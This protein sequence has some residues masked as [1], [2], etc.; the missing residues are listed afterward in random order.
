MDSAAEPVK[1]S[2]K[3]AGSS[4]VATGGMKRAHAACQS[5]VTGKSSAHHSRQRC[6]VRTGTAKVAHTRAAV[7]VGPG[8]PADSNPTARA[9]NTRRPKNR[10]DM[11]VV[12]LRHWLQQ[13]LKRDAKSARA[14]FRQPRG[15]RG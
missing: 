8:S 14:S 7:A 2:I 12:R 15:L 11:A 1:R 10:T 13:K 4:V 3:L 5:G 9:T 6:S